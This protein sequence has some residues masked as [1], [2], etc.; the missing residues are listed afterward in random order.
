MER[1]ILLFF[2]IGVVL[3]L[4]GLLIYKGKAYQLI[5]GYEF[6]KW[7]GADMRRYAKIFF[8]G[9][10]FM[11]VSIIIIPTIIFFL[12]NKLYAGRSIAIIIATACDAGEQYL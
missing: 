3:I 2:I 7:N 10:V 9:S 8:Q 4:L 12:W 5:S 11:G 1:D 6:L